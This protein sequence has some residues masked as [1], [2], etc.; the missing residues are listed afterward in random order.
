MIY[1]DQNYNWSQNVLACGD[2]CDNQLSHVCQFDNVND[3]TNQDFDTVLETFYQKTDQGNG[4]SDIITEQILT[5]EQPN[6]NRRVVVAPTEKGKFV[7]Y[8]KVN[9]I[10]ETRSK[11][12][13]E[14]REAETRKKL[15]DCQKIPVRNYQHQGN[16]IA[17]DKIWFQHNEGNAWHGPAEVV[18]Q[19]GNTIFAYSNGEM[20]KVA[21][22]RAKPYELIERKEEEKKS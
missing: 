22:C 5:Q 18:H 13:Q 16:Y 9:R 7:N 19:K 12:T 14:F 3:C 17:G 21:M 6:Y 4:V 8:E 1:N 10:I 2:N 20:R 15:K 11:I